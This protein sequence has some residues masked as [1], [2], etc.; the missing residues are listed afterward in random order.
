MEAAV[1][2]S[3]MQQGPRADAP[4]APP[5]LDQPVKVARPPKLPEQGNPPA[6]LI[7]PLPTG[8]RRRRHPGNPCLCL[9]WTFDR[10]C[11]RQLDPPDAFPV[12]CIVHLHLASPQPRSAAAT[13]ASASGTA[14]TADPRIAGIDHPKVCHYNPPPD[15]TLETLQPKPPPCSRHRPRPPWPARTNIA[16]ARRRRFPTRAP[17]TRRDSPSPVEPPERAHTHPHTHTRANEHTL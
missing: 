15:A 7:L 14:A 6:G 3:L 1:V 12:Y 16:R 5:D 4:G 11:E 10:A 13:A 17:S 8:T 2:A 9:D